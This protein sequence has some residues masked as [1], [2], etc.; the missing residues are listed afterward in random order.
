MK[1]TIKKVNENGYG[2]ITSETEGK[3]I[4]FHA[5]DCSA[6]NFKEM[7]AGDVVSYEIGDSPKGPKA[8]SVTLAE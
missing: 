6:Q 5:N 7:K 2:F 8:I 4:F 1:G 3:D